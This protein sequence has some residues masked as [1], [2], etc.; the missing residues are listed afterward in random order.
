MLLRTPAGCFLFI[1]FFFLMIRRPPRS[2]LFPYTTLFRS[3]RFSAPSHGSGYEPR[4]F[5][6]IACSTC[7]ADWNNDVQT[8]PDF[9]MAACP[10]L[11][12]ISDPAAT[13][14]AGGLLEQSVFLDVNQVPGRLEPSNG[15]RIYRCT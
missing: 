2:T 7:P 4:C 3:L 12:S 14:E 10:S 6:R 5:S 15:F 8:F 13:R 9:G 11:L 1:F